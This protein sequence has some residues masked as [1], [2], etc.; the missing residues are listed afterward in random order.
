MW[1]RCKKFSC[2]ITV[3]VSCLISEMC[4]PYILKNNLFSCFQIL[5]FSGYAVSTFMGY[6]IAPFVLQVS[7]LLFNIFLVQL[8][9]LDENS[10]AFE[11]GLV[12]ERPYNGKLITNRI[13]FWKMR[14][15]I[16]S[17]ARIKFPLHVLIIKSK[18]VLIL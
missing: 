9:C 2:N 17:L 5:A 15:D 3:F 8:L 16:C 14:T 12:T 6:T 4:I 7:S 18:S 13:L 1:T 10:F 11:F